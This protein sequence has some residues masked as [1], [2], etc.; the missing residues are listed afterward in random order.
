MY[1]RVNFLFMKKII[2]LLICSVFF[3]S[4]KSDKVFDK[5]GNEIIETFNNVPVYL[6]QGKNTRHKP[7]DGYN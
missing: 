5:K 3:I 7:T 4:C 2:L 6:H 1:Y